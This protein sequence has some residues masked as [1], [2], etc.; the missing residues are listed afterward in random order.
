MHI[1][2][3]LATDT[4]AG[5]N[6]ITGA[7]GMLGTHI[8]LELLKRGERVRGIKRPTSDLSIVKSVFEFYFPHEKYF[9]E[10][11][12]V[13][14]DVLDVCSLQDAM[15]GC[16][17][18]YHTAAIVS[19][20]AADRKNMYKT[21]VEGTANVVN[22][23]LEMKVH[24]LCHVSSIAALG[25]VQDGATLNENTEWKDSAQNTHY[26]ITKHLSELEVWRGIQEGLNALIVN[27]GFIIGPGDFSR[28]SNSIFTKLNEGLDYYPMGGTGVVGAV[29]CASM[30]V[31]LMQRNIHGE[32]FILVAENM[33]MKTLFEEVS[34]SLQK[35]K[36]AKMASEWVLQAARIAE[37]LKEKLTGRK[38]LV[39]KETVKNTS[40]HVLYNT[41]K[42]TSLLGRR[43]EPVKMS[44]QQTGAFFHSISK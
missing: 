33:K 22:C 5:M 28:S 26:G 2:D 11:E 9:S 16:T 1:Y 10:V 6:L 12:W 36:P 31:E 29:D 27:P 13:E 21:N 19:Y 32:Q 4:F 7:T 15:E 23:A 14:A 35:P 42:V 37:W 18:V 30:M 40:F 17:A 43:F 3:R 34:V 41:E 20:H 8:M 24:Q 25:K 44:I 39:T 38:A